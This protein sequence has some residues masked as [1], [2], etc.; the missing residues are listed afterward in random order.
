MKSKLLLLVMVTMMYIITSP[1]QSVFPQSGA[2]WNIRSSYS[3]DNGIHGLIG[4][5]VIEDQ[6]YQKLYLLNDENLILD[7]QDQY[8][9]A[10]LQ[11]DKK[12]WFRPHIPDYYRVPP[13]HAPSGCAPLRTWFS[14]EYLLPEQDFLLFDFSKNTGDTVYH[15]KYAVDFE[16]FYPRFIK[17]LFEE[18][19][20][21]ELISIIDNVSIN[22][23]AKTLHVT[24]G[25]YSF[26]H[27][28][29]VSYG[30]FGPTQWIEGIGGN[31]GLFYSEFPVPSCAGG[32]E[33]RKLGC[34]K[35]DNEVKYLD[36]ICFSC[37]DCY[38]SNSSINKSL[39]EDLSVFINPKDHFL[40]IRV[41]QSYAPCHIELINS[42]GQVILTQVIYEENTS[43][44]LDKLPKGIYVYQIGNNE[45]TF[46]SGK[47][48]I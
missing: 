29:W 9:G 26:K 6:S 1:A 18:E 44:P 31:Y 8:L 38:F 17:P 13:Q 47:I 14:S 21:V 39:Y 10:F 32:P 42:G 23:G 3:D 24:T 12:V 33:E 30:G 45:I 34:F 20:K 36:N 37:F 25:H 7:A 5:T 27:K 11:K 4:D 16:Y 19:D 46:R 22:N 15:G 2:I 35:S 41:N 28:G 48:I 40:E 43:I